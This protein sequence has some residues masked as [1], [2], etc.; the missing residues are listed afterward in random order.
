MNKDFV[1]ETKKLLRHMH[2]IAK[3]LLRIKKVRYYT[4]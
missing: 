3:L 2:D 1:K 4:R